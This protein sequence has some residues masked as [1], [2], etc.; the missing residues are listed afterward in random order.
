MLAMLVL[1]GSAVA[2][3]ATVS[4]VVYD[5]LSLSM[6]R[7][8]T[9]QFYGPTDGPGAR[10]VNATTDSRGAYRITGLV[11]G[12]YLAGFFHAS[13]D[14]LGLEMPSHVVEVDG[15]RHADLATPSPRSIS[16]AVCSGKSASDSTGILIGHLRESGSDRPLANARVHVDWS[17]TTIDQKR[18][19]SVNVVA[20]SE[21]TG[22]GW[23]A[24]CG[25][26]TSTPLIVRAE[27][28][29]DTTGD[30]R[31]ELPPS[32]V[33][34][35]TLYLAA[36]DSATRRGQRSRDARLAGMVLDAAGRPVVA[37]VAVWGTAANAATNERGQFQ[38]DSLPAGTRTV[39][40]RSIGVEP[41]YVVV[42]LVRGQTSRVD[43]RMQKVVALK[44]VE[45]RATVA[46]SKGLELFERHQRRSVGGVFVRPLDDALAGRDLIAITRTAF[47][48]DVSTDRNHNWHAYMRKPGGS[49]GRG[50]GKCEPTLYLDGRKSLDTFDDLYGYL[51]HDLILAVEI[52]PN[53]GEIPS[54]YPTEPL[55]PCGLISIWTRPLEIPLKKS[56]ADATP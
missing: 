38:F 6:L 24:V 7:G 3:Q 48:V 40:V 27:L 47:G 32:S 36:S 21:T 14:S 53:Y 13:L 12:R 8:A 33:A 29:G 56:P 39:E 37:D 55:S 50:L 44:A 34:H 52:Y 51:G 22:P 20:S 23:F 16:R 2:A 10:I 35:V 18:I 11:R 49:I 28:A 19:S 46:Y 4:G 26:P 45:I 31:V 17:E 9:V 30:I 41:K 25:V 1:N 15:D 54:D 5:S 43:I 42:D